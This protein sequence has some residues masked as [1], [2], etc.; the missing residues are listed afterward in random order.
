[1]RGSAHEAVSVVRV[2][3]ATVVVDIPEIVSVTKVRRTQPPRQGTNPHGSITE[4]NLNG[5]LW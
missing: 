4:L 1:M 5:I 2:V 3:V